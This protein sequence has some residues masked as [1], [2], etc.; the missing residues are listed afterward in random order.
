MDYAW[1]GTGQSIKSMLASTREIN[2]TTAISTTEVQ[3]FFFIGSIGFDSRNRPGDHMIIL[4]HHDYYD[5]FCLL[6]FVG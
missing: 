2:E 1:H 5:D 4:N 3:L 6:F